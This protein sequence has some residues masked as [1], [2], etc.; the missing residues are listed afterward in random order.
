MAGVRPTTW[1]KWLPLGKWMYNILYH[2]SI[3]MNPFEALY[4]FA[5]P[6]NI[7]Y[8]PKDSGVEIL[9]S[10]LCD[11][12]VNIGLKIEWNKWRIEK[13]LKDNTVSGIGS[14]WISHITSAHAQETPSPE[15]S[16]EV[17][18]ALSDS[19]E[20]WVSRLPSWPFTIVDDTPGVS[21][22]ATQISLRDDCIAKALTTEVP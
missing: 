7:P 15:V 14:L 3:K 21:C 10:L 12:E 8:F 9:D 6:F 5:P 13:D 19:G 1:V 2:S 11:N 17:L 22:L 4:K 20:D 18:Q 16:T